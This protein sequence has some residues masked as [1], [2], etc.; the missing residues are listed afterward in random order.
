VLGS[1]EKLDLAD[2]SLD[3]VFCHQTLHHLTDPAAALGEFGRVLRP[4]G[5]L[6]L[7]ESCR[8]F[9]DSIAVRALFRH[10]RHVHRTAQEYVELVSASG[11]EIRQI[12]HPDPFWSRP[13][14]GLLEWLGWP[15]PARA[16]PALLNLASQRPGGERARFLQC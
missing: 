11:F 4:G 1:A 14:K 8:S 9:L 7:S 13:D 15:A 5:L 2:A 12:S 3:L 10:P 6:L 16:Q